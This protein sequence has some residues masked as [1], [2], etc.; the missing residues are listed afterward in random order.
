MDKSIAIS[1]SVRQIDNAAINFHYWQQKLR[2]RQFR[3]NRDALNLIRVFELGKREPE[4]K[5]PFQW[6]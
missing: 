3:R 4:H 2:D 1:S 5:K 6:K